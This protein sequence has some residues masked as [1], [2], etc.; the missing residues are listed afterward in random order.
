[1]LL[2]SGFSCFCGRLLEISLP[3]CWSSS[4]RS[5]FRLLF[6]RR[7]ND[8]F[9]AALSSSTVVSRWWGKR[10]RGRWRAPFC[11]KMGFRRWTQLL[12]HG[13]HCAISSFQMG[14]STGG[15][16]VGGAVPPYSD[17]FLDWRELYAPNLKTLS[18][19]VPWFFC[20]FLSS[21]VGCF[22]IFQE[23]TNILLFVSFP[24]SFPCFI[25][26]LGRGVP[27]SIA[28]F[29]IVRAFHLILD[30]GCYIVVFGISTHISVLHIRCIASMGWFSI[31]L[32]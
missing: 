9:P 11:P 4:S 32:V 5:I 1:M 27:T 20:S 25:H 26:Q 16:H 22:S 31:V 13:F 14:G 2:S 7:W 24:I 23:C 3:L 15:L 8:F 17:P 18:L 28:S 21:P 19:V 30:K 10:G 6:P 12:D 29:L